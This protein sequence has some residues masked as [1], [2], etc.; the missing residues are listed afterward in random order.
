M[1]EK[2]ILVVDDDDMV[3][4]VLERILSQEFKVYTAESGEKA[5]EEFDQHRPDIILADYMM[6]KMNGFDMMDKLHEKYGRG[7]FTIFMTANDQEDTEI[8]VYK[9]G[10]LAFLRKPIKADELLTTIRSSMDKLEAM[11]KNSTQ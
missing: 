2:S 10:A 8:E 5:L 6:P 4:M 11:R 7:I 9:H 3:L 1:F